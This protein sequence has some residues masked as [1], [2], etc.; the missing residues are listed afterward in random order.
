MIQVA[1]DNGLGWDYSRVGCKKGLNSGNI[2]IIKPMGFT[3]GVRER[4]N[5]GYERTR[6][7]SDAYNSLAWATGKMKL[8]LSE[9]GRK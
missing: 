8:L 1:N 4:L 2:S 3:W 6:G 9:R 7:R 5:V